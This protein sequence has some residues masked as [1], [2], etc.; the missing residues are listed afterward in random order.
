FDA[1]IDR[2]F[3]VQDRM[4]AAVTSA[5]KLSP[6]LAPQRGQSPCDGADPLAYRAYL[7]GQYQN[8]R[9][10]ADRMAEALAAF[11]EAIDRD[12]TCD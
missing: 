3:T 5:L 8:N 12:P 2:V 10:S 6:A 1:P 9:P 4:S 11:R 7:R